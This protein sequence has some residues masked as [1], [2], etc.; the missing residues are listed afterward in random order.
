MWWSFKGR[1][2]PC[3]LFMFVCIGLASSSDHSDYIARDLSAQRLDESTIRLEWKAPVR[4]DSIREYRIVQGAKRYLF[5]RIKVVN[6]RQTYVIL[7]NMPIE[8]TTLRV[9]AVRKVGSA[10]PFSD[11]VAVQPLYNNSF[12]QNVKGERL[13]LTTVRLTWE[14]PNPRFAIGEYRVVEG[15]HEGIWKRIAVVEGEAR[16]VDLSGITSEP[17]YMQV[18]AVLSD[19]RKLAMSEQ[20][21]VNVFVS[22]PKIISDPLT[23]AIENHPYHYQV[24]VENG[25]D[26]DLSFSLTKS[27]AGLSIDANTGLVSGAPLAANPTG[28]TVGIRVSDGFKSATQEFELIIDPNHVP[29]IISSPLVHILEGESY[30]YQAEGR[31]DD[32]DSLIWQVSGPAGM[33]I[34]ETTGLLDWNAP[35]IG[36]HMVTIT[37]GDGFGAS[38]VQQYALEVQENLAP[39]IVSI[40][41]TIAYPDGEYVYQVEAHDPE[42]GVLSY[43]LLEKPESQ[44]MTIDFQSG[45]VTMLHNTA[46]SPDPSLEEKYIISIEVSDGFKTNVQTFSLY[47]R[48]PSKVVKKVESGQGHSMFLMADGSLWSAGINI[49]G[50][51]G[52]GTRTTRSNSVEIFNSGIKD[53]SCGTYHT[54]VL[55]DDGSVW[56]FGLSVFG[57]LGRMYFSE[58]PIELYESGIQAIGAGEH[59]T[60]V[61]KNDGSVWGTGLN[62]YDNL[63]PKDSDDYLEEVYEPRKISGNLV[64]KKMFTDW[65]SNFFVTTDDK[66]FAMGNN[67]RGMLAD[68]TT[69]N[70]PL[71]VEISIPG[72][73]THIDVGGGH[74]FFITSDG[75]LRVAGSNFFGK[76]GLGDAIGAELPYTELFGRNVLLAT[77]GIDDSLLIFKDETTDMQQH[78]IKGA[79]F[80]DYGELGVGNN[81][82][83]M[84]FNESVNLQNNLR[85]HQC[86][87]SWYT[88][89]IIDEK[90]E[91]HASGDNTY[92]QFGN[93]TTTSSNTFIK[94]NVP[95]E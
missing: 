68:G 12:A 47:V 85:P 51:L 19:G 81:E 14:A 27:P 23:R 76:A 56:G 58:N 41:E 3:V 1:I 24:L 29:V 74:A 15:P 10:V 17:T 37:L 32:G 61:L 2:A 86:H 28:E 13:D 62:V 77:A 50:Q 65:W 59:T 6:A 8:T 91:V 79:G 45:K 87:I 92:G 21:E 88:A 73:V 57:Q 83:T 52:D 60:L 16:S 48:D 4:K 43:R 72:Q 70:R 93:G 46:V 64:V 69:S 7:K 80:N 71:P 38:T 75:K 55:K 33:V 22:P 53:V 94:V 31:D 20:V 36:S 89:Y 63:G 39:S 5:K 90:G 78:L 26:K 34:D 82:I 30:T 18:R 49:Y 42:N 11:P 9:R 40:P 54:V 25:E 95:G 44:A 67:E 66:L 35:A 84:V